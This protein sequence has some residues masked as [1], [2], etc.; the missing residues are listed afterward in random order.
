MIKIRRHTY[1]SVPYSQENI[2][3]F[4][5]P[6]NKLKHAR[7]SEKTFGW[8]FINKKTEELVGYVGCEGNMIVALEVSEKFRG[9]GY[10]SRLLSLADSCGATRLSVNKS[11]KH[12]IDVYLHLGYEEYDSDKN[13]IYMK[14]KRS[15]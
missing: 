1:Y 15:D 13:M 12:A 8:F 9:R 5:S 10:S 11:N 6:D 3:R 7:I 2:D 4:K 14:K